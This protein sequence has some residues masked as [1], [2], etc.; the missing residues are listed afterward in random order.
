MVPLAFKPFAANGFDNREVHYPP[1]AI[2]L[3]EGR[4]GYLY[5]VVVAMEVGALRLVVV[6][7]M[8]AANGVLA[9]ASG[10]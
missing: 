6:N 10:S 8:P 9:S 3:V 4:A 1:H 7:S 5:R 2:E